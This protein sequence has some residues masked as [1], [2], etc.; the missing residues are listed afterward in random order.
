[1]TTI[2]VSAV[3]VSLVFAAAVAVY[4]VM[5]SKLSAERRFSDAR[6]KTL[7]ATFERML[8]RVSDVTAEKL[9]ERE[10]QLAGRNVEQVK[11]LFDAM[12]S[13]IERFKAAAETAQKENIAL[14]A[15]L[16]SQIGEVGEKAA[17]LGRQADEFVTALK[18]G[19]KLQG[20]WGEGILEKVL[21]DAGLEKGVN[22]VSQTG[23]REGGL[24]DVRVFDGEGHEI[25]IDAKVNID[26]FLAAGNAEREGR[27]EEA[28]KRLAAHAKSV[29]AQI[30][31]LSAKKYA[32]LVIMFMPSEATYSAALRADASLAAYANSL[33]VVLASPQMVFGYLVL[34]KMGLDRIR[35][36]RNNAEIAK[37]AEQIVSRMDGAF[38]ALDRLGRSL[39]DAL[40]KYHETLGKLGLEPGAQNV[41]TPAKELIRLAASVQKRNSKMLQEQ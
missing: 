29:R 13:D 41:L 40:S 21:E 15:A 9:S 36:D 39:E 24:P 25:V 33:G 31:G 19:N 4:A 27:P 7:S 16:R 8:Q 38:T 22:Y 30:A 28:A 12:K 2:I 26:D 18:S 5:A 20:N 32:P 34:F 11:P 3:V 23:S 17:G 1:M 6:E 14:G 35:V 37:R 10:R